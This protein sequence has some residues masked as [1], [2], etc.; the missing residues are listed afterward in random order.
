[1]TLCLLLLRTEFLLL[2]WLIPMTGRLLVSIII[3]IILGSSWPHPP[4]HSR[5]WPGWYLGRGLKGA[6]K[7][8]GCQAHLSP[9]TKGSSLGAGVAC[10]LKPQMGRWTMTWGG[11]RRLGH[12]ASSD[13]AEVCRP[14]GA[15]GAGVDT[16][17]LLAGCGQGAILIHYTLP[18]GNR[19]DLFM[20]H[21]R[22]KEAGVYLWQAWYGSPTVPVGHSQ[23]QL[24]PWT[25]RT[26]G[27]LRGPQL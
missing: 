15:R 25:M 20:F 1:M 9:I 16:L 12:C 2:L 18:S 4:A 21:K 23:E 6:D 5:G 8:V 24:S 19:S 10:S 11:V 13:P 3:I 14:A 7:M 17:V 22:R 26:V 27:T